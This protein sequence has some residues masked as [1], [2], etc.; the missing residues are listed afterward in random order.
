MSKTFQYA[1]VSRLNGKIKVRF[2]ARDVYV[3]ALAKSNN[4]DVDLVDLGAPMSKEQAIA[5]LIQSEFGKGN[6][7]IQ[8]ALQEASERRAVK[9][10]RDEARASGQ[11]A[12]RGRKPRAVEVPAA[13]PAAAEELEAT[14]F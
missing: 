1:G 12:R 2:S 11:P 6:P 7:E 3:K 14:P 4:T 5:F 10:A 13:E 9:Q 8:S